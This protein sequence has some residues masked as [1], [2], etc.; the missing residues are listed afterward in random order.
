[1]V[2][3]L[4]LILA[5][6]LLP[7]SAI[8]ATNYYISA[9]G[10]GEACTS[11][12]PCALATAVAAATNGDTIFFKSDDTWEGASNQVLNATTAGVSYDGS[13]YGT[14]TRATLKATGEL[15]AVVKLSAS[16]LSFKGF[17]IDMNSQ[18]TG[19]IYVGTFAT[20][21]IAGITIDDCKVHDSSVP[22]GHYRYGIHVGGYANTN[23]DVD[24]VTI[25][26]TEVYNTGHEAFAIYPTWTKTG[27]TAKNV[28]IRNCSGHHAGLDGDDWGDGL[29]IVNGVEN[30]IVEYS[31]FYS[32]DRGITVGN[33]SDGYTGD[34]VGVKIRYNLSYNNLTRGIGCQSGTAENGVTGTIDIYGNVIYGNG[35]NGISMGGLF[36]TST[37]NIYNN[38]VY[39]SST[40][41]YALL[42]YNVSGTGTPFNIKNN[43]FVAD[44]FYLMKFNTVADEAL[45][46]HSNNL[47][48][49][50]TGSTN[51]WYI[52]ND[53]AFTAANVKDTWD[54][55]SQNT[56]PA[57]SG[58]TL[59]TGFS[60]TYGSNMVPNTDYFQL[61]VDSPAKDAGATLASYTG[62][63]NGAGLATPIVRPL[64]AAYDIGAYEYGT[65]AQSGG[66]AACGFFFQGVTIR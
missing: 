60:G 39:S 48:Y 47:L 18:V 38:T 44:N 31:S 49:R 50:I 64:G 63:I 17:N 51:Q 21:D 58:G 35:T 42:L 5:L 26:N 34:P 53:V 6:I 45:V 65:V 55:T 54:D 4:L 19:G 61:T 29:Y 15:D 14:G 12:S 33:S 57:F 2:R 37:I 59:P 22:T 3:K 7:C 36:N 8:A 1:M 23:I 41:G 16:T 27:C 62:A 30:V 43:I 24:T 66:S 46:S 13:T 11:G 20:A 9:A 56:A 28:I 40:A 52:I 25:T 10:S 32:N